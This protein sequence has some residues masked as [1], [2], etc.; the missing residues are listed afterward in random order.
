MR[1]HFNV[2]TFLCISMLFIVSNCRVTSIYEYNQETV[3]LFQSL[4]DKI[5]IDRLPAEFRAQNRA[6]VVDNIRW[7]CKKNMP[8]VPVEKTRVTSNVITTRFSYFILLLS[9]KKE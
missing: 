7:C 2:G 9:F 6:I 5:E 8:D 3:D 1:S 4:I